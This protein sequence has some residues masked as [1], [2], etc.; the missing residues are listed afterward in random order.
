MKILRG[1][2][3][4]VHLVNAYEDEKKVYFVMEI[5]TGGPIFERF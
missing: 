3:N 2:L 5:C 4:V 1:H